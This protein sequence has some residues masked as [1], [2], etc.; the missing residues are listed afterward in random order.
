MLCTLR[1]QF[2]GPV[3]AGR[4]FEILPGT[5]QLGQFLNWSMSLPTGG[6]CH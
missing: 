2:S 3:G 6:K 1:P 5:S 4:K